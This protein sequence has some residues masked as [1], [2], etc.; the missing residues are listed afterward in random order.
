MIVATGLLVGGCG[1]DS[2]DKST[3]DATPGGSVS[4]DPDDI[5]LPEIMFELEAETQAREVRVEQAIRDCMLESGFEYFPSLSAA[6]PVPDSRKDDRFRSMYG[7]GVAQLPETMRSPTFDELMNSP[8]A[9]YE[10]GLGEAEA[11]AYG[12]ALAGEGDGVS[13]CRS[14][15]DREID[16]RASELLAA[17]GGYAFGLLPSVFSDQRYVEAQSAWSA[18]MADAGYVVTDLF[19]AV[20]LAQQRILDFT[21]EAGRLPLQAELDLLTEQEVQQAETDQGCYEE[22]VEDVE[23][24]ISEEIE[25]AIAREAAVLVSEARALL[26]DR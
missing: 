8:N 24:E 12:N 19:S 18:C 26:G 10:A 23:R 14:Q 20:A 6:A 22:H 4:S 1:Q 15:A 17:I 25:R 13:G 2:D 9:Q 21:A 16:D 3:F 5:T 11:A 7:Y